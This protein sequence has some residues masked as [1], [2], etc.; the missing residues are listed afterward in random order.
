MSSFLPVAREIL[1]TTSDQWNSPHYFSY[2]LFST[3]HD[4]LYDPRLY[5]IICIYVR[6]L[7]FVL[8]YKVEILIPT[9]EMEGERERKTE[10]ASSRSQSPSHAIP[11][12]YCWHAP[13]LPVI[14]LLTSPPT[15]SLSNLLGIFPRTID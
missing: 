2:S 11:Y 6:N 9:R 5:H 10:E 3:N 8:V 7:C 12:I 13:F 4:A 14:I 1:F 15:S